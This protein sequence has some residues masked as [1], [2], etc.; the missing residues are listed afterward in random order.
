MID[1]I[2][3]LKDPET[4]VGRK[5]MVQVK[6]ATRHYATVSG[7]VM[8]GGDGQAPRLVGVYVKDYRWSKPRWTAAGDILDLI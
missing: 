8:D 4:L 1:S 6:D 7:V 3:A 5:V 2:K